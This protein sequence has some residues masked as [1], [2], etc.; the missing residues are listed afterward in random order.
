VQNSASD[1]PV[2]NIRR[3]RNIRR[4]AAR[5]IRLLGRDPAKMGR[6][7]SQKADVAPRLL[8]W[9]LMVDSDWIEHRRGDR[10]LVGWIV[11]RG[12]DFVVVDLLG[13]ER[14]GPVDWLRAE[15]TLDELGIGYLADIYMLTLDNGVELRVRIAEVSTSGIRVKKDDFGAV[16]VPHLYYEL[17]FPAPPTLRPLKPEDV[18]VLSPDE[19]GLG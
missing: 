19:F 1:E 8:P 14:G 4:R 2:D 11:P 16:G 18:G 15:E 13:R 10:E 9:R 7:S 12:E 3:R 17:A 5:E 6:I